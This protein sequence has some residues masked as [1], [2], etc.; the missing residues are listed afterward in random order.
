M[1]MGDACGQKRPTR[2]APS[3]DSRFPRITNRKFSAPNDEA[4]FLVQGFCFMRSARLRLVCV[5][6]RR[7]HARIANRDQRPVQQR[8]VGKDQHGSFQWNG[9]AV[10]RPL[11]MTY[12]RLEFSGSSFSLSTIRQSSATDSALIFRIMLLRW[13][14]TVVSVMPISPAI[15]LF[16]RPPHDLYQNRALTGR[17]LFEPCSERAQSQFILA[18]R[19]VASEPRNSRPRD[20]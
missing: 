8:S 14:F 18:A 20:S 17:Q 13:T 19:T 5:A 15:C 9:Q 7:D 4:S 3:S 16:R 1:P 10:L 6:D 12:D 2:A 11:Y